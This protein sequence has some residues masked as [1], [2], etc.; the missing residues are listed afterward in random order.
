MYNKLNLYQKLLITEIEDNNGFLYAYLLFINIIPSSFR[1]RLQ[2]MFVNK[3]TI[4]IIFSGV[5]ETV[6]VRENGDI[7]PAENVEAFEMAFAN[8]E[9][10]A[11]KV[12]PSSPF[13]VG[14]YYSEQ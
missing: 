12:F 4:I 6:F 5:G 11:E 7:V 13:S 14:Q 3:A 8:L 1:G 10:Q 2:I 9:E